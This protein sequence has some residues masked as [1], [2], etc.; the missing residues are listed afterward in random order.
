MVLIYLSRTPFGVHA[1]PLLYGQSSRLFR[2][3]KS[4]VPRLVDAMDY[5]NF[6]DCVVAHHN[7]VH[8]VA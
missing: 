6:I 7:A 5:Y 2:R 1:E 8:D 4:L 3:A